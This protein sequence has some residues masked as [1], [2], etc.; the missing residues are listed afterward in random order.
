MARKPGSAVRRLGAAALVFAALVTVIG[1]GAAPA[2]RSRSSVSRAAV[3]E[4][5]FTG[6][7]IGGTDRYRHLD[8]HASNPD[9]HIVTDSNDGYRGRFLYSFRIDHGV[10]S[11]TGEGVYQSATWHLQGTNGKNGG[12]SCDV[13]VEAQP[14]SVLVT[15]RAAKGVLTVHFTLQDAVETN[16]DYDCGAH[17]T[18]FAT[19][20]T[21][22]ADSLEAVQKA[23]GGDL[24][25]SRTSPTFPDLSAHDEQQSSMSK[26]VASSEWTITISAPKASGGGGGRA[27]GS[28]D[29]GAKG[30]GRAGCTIKGTAHRDVLVGTPGPDVI[31]GFAGNDVIRGLGGN[32]IVFGGLGNDVI[33]GGAGADSVH[34]NGGKDRL[35]ARDNERDVVDGGPGR[36]TAQ[37]DPGKDRVRAIEVV[38]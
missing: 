34:G 3:F 27:A 22:L 8:N 20:S 18:G 4:G 36:D 15:G 17:Y 16:G 6:V 9:D 29:T 2:A 26:L 31:C 7:G 12:F 23:Q 5:P 35:L 38:G 10:I 32:D 14:F 21:Y 1:A 25:T 37:V 11:G 24:T 33:D 30:P 28:N 13:P 19:T